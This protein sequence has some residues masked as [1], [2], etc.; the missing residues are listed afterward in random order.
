MLIDLKSKLNESYVKE[1]I[2]YSGFDEP[3]ELEAYIESY[4]TDDKLALYGLES[5]GE[6]VGI[7]GFRTVEGNSIYITRIAVK[8]E[9]RGLGF[10]RGLLLEAIDKIHPAQIITE[11]DEEFVDFYRAVGFEIASLGETNPGHERFKCTYHAEI[12]S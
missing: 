8:P 2:G 6:I 5:E 12:I 4:K 10:G 11:T 7:I 9:C 3:E 1:L